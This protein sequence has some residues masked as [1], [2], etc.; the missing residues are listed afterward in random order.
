MT[1]RNQATQNFACAVAQSRR[2]SSLFLLRL[3]HPNALFLLGGCRLSRHRSLLLEFRKQNCRTR[4]LSR[5]KRFTTQFQSI[6]QCFQMTYR[7]SS[8]ANRSRTTQCR[9][10]PPAQRNS[11]LRRRTSSTT[12]RA[13]YAHR[14]DRRR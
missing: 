1:A 12:A 11:R 6:Y 7:P 8:S 4:R 9:L 3:L 10:K 5:F 2:A 14:A 13:V